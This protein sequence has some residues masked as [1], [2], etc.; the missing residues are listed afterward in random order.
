[1]MMMMMMLT[2][3]CQLALTLD[4]DI[5]SIE[6]QLLGDDRVSKGLYTRSVVWKLSNLCLAKKLLIFLNKV[7]ISVW[8][9]SLY[10]RNRSTVLFCSVFS[11]FVSFCKFIS[12]ILTTPPQCTMHLTIY[13]SFSLS[14]QVQ[15]SPVPQILFITDCWYS[16]LPTRLHLQNLRYFIG[17]AIHRFSF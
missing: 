11:T 8:V 17:C 5:Q 2:T 4:T 13:Y 16:S 6:E 1:M 9:A 7:C 14:F 3:C 15:N 10:F 12:A